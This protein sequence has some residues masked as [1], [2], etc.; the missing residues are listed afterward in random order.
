MATSYSRF[1]RQATRAYSEQR[2]RN[3]CWLRWE[4]LVDVLSFFAERLLTILF[5]PVAI[6]W[7]DSLLKPDCLVHY[8]IFRGYFILTQN[9]NTNEMDTVT[10]V[11]CPHDG[12]PMY[13]AEINPA[14]R[15]CRRWT[16]PQCGARRTNEEGLV[17]LTSQEI[18]DLS[19]KNAEQSEPEGIPHT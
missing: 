7:V 9:G 1:K 14:K 12:A 15:G 2:F 5:N 19:E 13:L 4:L 6:L 3:E 17:G 10:R 11:R 18:Q 16:C 8:N